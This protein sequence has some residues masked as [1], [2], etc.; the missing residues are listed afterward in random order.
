MRTPHSNGGL[1][2]PRQ[3]R[4]GRRAGDDLGAGGGVLASRRRCGHRMGSMRSMRLLLVLVLVLVPAMAPA[5]R[6]DFTVATVQRPT[7]ISSYAGHVVWSRYDAAL[8]AFRLMEA[9]ASAAGQVT[10][11]LPVAARA[12]PFDADVGPDAN[13]APT[14]VYSRCATEPRLG[15]A[16]AG[17]PV[18]ATGG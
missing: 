18:W 11:A 13:G 8:G 3:G 4:D 7:P 16:P 5:A 10:T 12:V 1:R 14:V 17:I 2:A 6:A 9:H 15:V